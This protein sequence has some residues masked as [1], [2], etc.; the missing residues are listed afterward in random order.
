MFVCVGRRMVG[1][2]LCVYVCFYFSIIELLRRYFAY[3]LHVISISPCL[4]TYTWTS[5]AFTYTFETHLRHSKESFSCV[6]SPTTTTLKLP[7]KSGAHATILRG[8]S[9]KVTHSTNVRSAEFVSA[10]VC[11]CV[12]AWHFLLI[13]GQKPASI[14]IRLR[15]PGHRRSHSRTCDL[16]A[17]PPSHKRGGMEIAHAWP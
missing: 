16:F 1:C 6:D 10:L 8:L 9:A 14:F 17:Q 5:I 12:C 2:I 4:P 13:G 3:Q 11:L 15:G 7:V